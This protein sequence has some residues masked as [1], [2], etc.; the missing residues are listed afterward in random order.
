V[1]ATAPFAAPSD[2]EAIWRP[3]SDAE[4]VQAV[5]LLNEASGLVLEIPQVAARVTAGLVPD[6]TLKS[7]VVRMV[8]RV[9]L[10][11]R[12]L[13]QF[14][15]TVDDVSRS[16]T[17]EAGLVP[18]GELVVSPGELD[19][20]MG[21]VGLAGAFTV[22]QPALLVPPDVDLGFPRG[23]DLNKLYLLDPTD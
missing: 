13:S 23:A 11:P 1:T 21:R 22:L 7:V 16:G 12:R 4:T 3:L 8:L 14:S 17:F 20:L 9:L 10:N 18:A 2:V 5:G 19:R 15:D 6:A